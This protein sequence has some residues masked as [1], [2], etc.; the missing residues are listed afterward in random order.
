M[1]IA[2]SFEETKG[3]STSGTFL[4]AAPRKNNFLSLQLWFAFSILLLG[5]AALAALK[6]RPS[7]ALTAFGDLA[8]LFL[9]GSAAC[10]FAQTM[11]WLVLFRIFQGFGAGSIQSI[12]I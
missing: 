8:Q 10:G 7:Y 2:P 4:S 1:S 12:A 11:F 5:I 9:V 3:A 6:A